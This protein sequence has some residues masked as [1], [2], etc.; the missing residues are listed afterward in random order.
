[1]YFCAG[2]PVVKAIAAEEV[3]KK[4]RKDGY[5][6]AVATSR[7]IAEGLQIERSFAKSRTRRRRRL[8]ECEA[9][10]EGSEVSPEEN[11]KANLFLPLMDHALSSL[12]E[13]FEQMHTVGAIFNFL[14]NQESLLQVYGHNRLLNACQKFYE[15]ISDI[16]PMEMNEELERFVVIVK[17]NKEDFKTA[18]DFL[19]YIY[20]KHMLE[21][22]PNLSIALRVLLT[23]P[24][25]VAGAERSFSKLKLIKTFHRS[26]MMDKRLTS[27]ATISIESSCV[28]DLDLDRII[29][30]FAAEKARR[31]TF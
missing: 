11:F 8:Y 29:D 25:S 10:D 20:R 2:P 12:K 19:S 7:E 28:R 13:R 18:D 3:L 21:V 15:T 30:V 31:K 24:V 14:Y 26:T 17:E 22:Y 6:G 27:L 1:M 23:C 4:Y 9:E 5:S 16:N